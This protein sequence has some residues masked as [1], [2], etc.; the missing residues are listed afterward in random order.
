MHSSP[1][2]DLRR[3]RRFTAALVACTLAS[4]LL[5][6]GCGR[7]GG[8][9]TNSYF[10][11]AQPPAREEFRW[12][13]G[14]AP[15]SFDPAL[16]SAPPETDVVRAI[17]EGLTELDPETLEAMP[18]VAESWSSSTD[19]RVWTFKLRGDARWTNGEPVT[20][21]DFV[22]SWRRLAD[23][24]EAGPFQR[25]RSNIVGMRSRPAGPAAA[26]TTPS[27]TPEPDAAEQETASS[28]ATGAGSPT[29]GD[30]PDDQ[31]T[32]AAADAEFGVAARGDLI[33]EV[34]L[35]I[36]DPDLPRLVAHPV[37]RPVH[38]RSDLASG[39][40]PERIVT[41]GA[42]RIAS[43]GPDGVVLERS[44]VYWDRD[45][46]RLATVRLVP[47]SDASDALDEYK[48]GRLDA[49]T[50]AE[51]EPLALKLLSPY[52]D[53]RRVTH[54]AINL[55]EF[56]TQ[57]APFS[58][59]RVRRALAIAIERERLAEGELEGSVRPALRY[60]PFGGE[61]GV[62]IIQDAA[63]AKRLLADAG[64]PEGEGFPQ[65]KLVVNRNETQQRIARLVARMWKESLGISSIV[66]VRESGEMEAVR[67]SGDYDLIRRGVVYPT[68]DAA[69][70]LRSL[71]DYSY[72]AVI[73]RR[74][75]EIEA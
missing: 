53:F 55:Y 60:L 54:A 37:F 29:P 4:A 8:V 26:E 70:N 50:N 39:A 5:A 44:P 32:N 74:E 24:G 3:T 67:E 61:T 35:L 15:K 66:E 58:D 16:A 6:G 71:F 19:F 23:L 30:R 63:E 68:S 65:V 9:E 33:L 56:N 20:A 48:A 10:S 38:G 40:S 14:R 2:M 31:K 73:A 25:L 51:F 62:G 42:Y 22:R 47:H 43:A 28:P 13:N 59:R 41:N 18:A 7:S 12:S 72:A 11:A 17:F 57:K 1:Q 36:G 34:R 75:A 64:Y 46:V 27:P 21:H 45:S 69:A 52:E 49:V